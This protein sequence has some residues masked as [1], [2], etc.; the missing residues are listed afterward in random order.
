MTAVPSH[1]SSVHALLSL[2]HAVADAFLASAGQAAAEPVQFSARSHS[3][4]AARQTLLEAA[5]AS[6]GQ[7]ALVPSQDSAT[8]HVPAL[9]RQTVLDRKS[10]V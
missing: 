8:S 3:P 6:A 4:A 5:K 9:A 7:A 10:V 1:W 2:V